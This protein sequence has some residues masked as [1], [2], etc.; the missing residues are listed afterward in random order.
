MDE[1]TLKEYEKKVLT[2][3][4]GLRGGLWVWVRT[5][6]DSQ[7]NIFLNFSYFF[8]IKKLKHTNFE[9]VYMVQ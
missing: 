6:K 4:E 3:I 8:I 1:V 2:K 5:P 9:Q 7:L